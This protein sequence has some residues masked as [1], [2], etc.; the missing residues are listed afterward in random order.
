MKTI[1]LTDEES[2]AIDCALGIVLGMA[3]GAKIV[4]LRA[5]MESARLKIHMEADDFNAEHY[6]LFGPKP[7]E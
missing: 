5:A 2:D 6:F 4:N 1:Y 7:R 3:E